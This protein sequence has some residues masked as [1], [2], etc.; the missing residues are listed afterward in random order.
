MDTKIPEELTIHKLTPSHLPAS[1]A[2]TYQSSFS[3]P[4]CLSCREVGSITP[5]APHERTVAPSEET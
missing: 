3:A 4:G 5:A 2:P 1:D